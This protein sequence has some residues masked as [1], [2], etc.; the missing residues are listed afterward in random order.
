MEI[1]LTNHVF[2]PGEGELL[3]WGGP[4]AGS[5]TIMVDPQNSPPTDLCVLTQSLD[6]GS[7][8]PVHHHEEAEQVLVI[9]SGR[10]DILLAGQRIEAAAGSTVHV[11]KSIAHGIV[12]TGAAPLTI[13]EVTS[14][15]GFQNIFRE[16]HQLSEPSLEDIA[17]IGAKYDIVMHPGDT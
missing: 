1:D 10:A 6:V 2:N 5:V 16:M 8:I 15:P 4:A 14:P 17:R 7:A 12:N 3:H 11:P 13:L 9:V